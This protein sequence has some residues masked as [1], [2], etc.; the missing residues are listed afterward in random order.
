MNGACGDEQV[1]AFLN[2]IPRT[3]FLRG[4]QTAHLSRAAQTTEQSVS[5]FRSLRD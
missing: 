4:K 3:D 1:E 2:W 5:D